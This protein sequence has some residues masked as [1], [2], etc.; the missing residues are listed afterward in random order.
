MNYEYKREKSGKRLKK[1]K[2]KKQNGRS[3]PSLIIV[4]Y[5][6]V[7]STRAAE[8]GNP[9]ETSFSSSGIEPATP[10]GILHTR[11]TG[12]SYGNTTPKFCFWKCAYKRVG[13]N[14][15]HNV[16]Y[17]NMSVQ[18]DSA[19]VVLFFFLYFLSPNS[20]NITL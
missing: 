8:D 3:G 13:Y 18:R 20:H 1:K 12:F 10:P 5:D 11:V 2:T 6:N 15:F 19:V 4:W 14:I 17:Y 16:H 9:K 7:F